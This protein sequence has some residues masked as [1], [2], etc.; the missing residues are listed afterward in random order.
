MYVGELVQFADGE[1]RLIRRVC[2]LVSSFNFG[3]A[4]VVAFKAEL[5]DGTTRVVAI[6][7]SRS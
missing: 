1:Q 4:Q 5:D 7:K 2:S 6:R 3:G